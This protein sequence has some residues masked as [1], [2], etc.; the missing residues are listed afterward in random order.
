[1]PPVEPGAIFSEM[2]AERLL[3]CAHLD[4]C[5]RCDLARIVDFAQ[6]VR[7][8]TS[9][10]V[11]SCLDKDA[12]SAI[13]FHPLEPTSA[14]FVSRYR[15]SFQEMGTGS[16]DDMGAFRVL[17]PIKE[18][19]FGVEAANNQFLS[20]CADSDA[21]YYPII[22]AENDYDLNLMN[23][24]MGLLSRRQATAH[25]MIDGGTK[26]IPVVLLPKYD[27]GFCLSVHKSQGSEFDHVVLLL[28][29]GSER[30]GRKMLY[31]AITRARKKIDVYGSVE[32]L[33][34]IIDKDLIPQSIAY[35]Y[36]R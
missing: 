31:T 6:A 10:A 1:M 32:T 15:K 18:G 35:E 3:P 22:I 17:C 19:P 4:K 24:Q 16:L 25:F 8:G 14:A 36:K 13:S 11:V 2:V 26:H 29:P 23:G 9:D 30:F 21:A 34:A 28:P 20:L 27:L 12:D 7:V 33:R 5:L